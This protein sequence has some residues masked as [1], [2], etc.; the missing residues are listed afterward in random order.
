YTTQNFTL[1]AGEYF[2][3][4]ER[5]YNNG[6]NNQFTVNNLTVNTVSGGAAPFSNNNISSPAAKKDALT[7]ASTY[8]NN[9]RKGNLNL[10]VLGAAP[11]SQIQIA[12]TNS[13]FKWGTAVPDNLSTYL[14]NS[15][16]ITRLKNDFNS[17]TPENAGKW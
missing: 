12:E 16:Y 1:P 9:F 7:A 10:S 11:G 13:A 8:I 6:S 5:D 17:V 2:V 15:T 14:N 3:R 4:V